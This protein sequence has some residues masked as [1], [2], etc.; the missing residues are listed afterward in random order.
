[1]R[2]RLNSKAQDW[3]ADATESNGGLV[4]LRVVNKAYIE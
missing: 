2:A 1:M 4:H 3:L